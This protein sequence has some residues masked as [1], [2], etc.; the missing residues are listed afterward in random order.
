MM[1]PFGACSECH[2]DVHSGQFA[3][4]KE[5]GRCETRHLETGFVPTLFG[6]QM[7]Q[8]TRFPLK[9]A[10]QAVPCMMCHVNTETRASQYT[11]SK[12]TV[13]SREC[14]QGPH[15]D[16][17]LK[18]IAREGCESCHTVSAWSETDVNHDLTRFPL[19]GGHL[20]VACDR[21]HKEVKISGASMRVYEAAPGECQD[22]HPDRHGGQFA[23]GG[24]VACARCHT[25]VNWKATRFD[26]GRDVRFP[27][28]GAFV[29]VACEKCHTP[30]AYSGDTDRHYRPLDATCSVCH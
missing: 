6:M 7:H 26:H 11:L 17:F 9:G 13:T 22:C 10:H 5:G 12:E 15:G 23:R 14:H 29:S 3:R 28:L 2:K 27:L 20:Q 19:I 30:I 16:Q 25:Q 18:R 1:P 8:D 21:C 24:I 4:R